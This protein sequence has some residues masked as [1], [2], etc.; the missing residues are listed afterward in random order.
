M[1]KKVLGRGL[2][3]LIPDAAATEPAPNEIDIDRITANPDQ[4]RLRFDEQRLNE[5]AESIRQNGILQPLLVRRSG[6]NYQLVAGER[7][8]MAAQRAGLLK[9]PAYIRDIPD[10]RLLEAALI[11]NIQREQLNPI[12]EAQAY[13]NLMETLACTQE[14]LAT[15][16]GKD[17]STIANSLRLL[18]LPSAVK[19][20]VAEGELSPGHARALLSA[21][22]SPAEITQ[23]ARLMI[24]KGWSV[25]EAERWAKKTPGK[26]SD[27]QLPVPDPNVSAAE[28]RL[29]VLLGTRVEIVSADQDKGYIRIHFF[30][31]DDLTRIFGIIAENRKH[32]EGGVR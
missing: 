25:R 12:E 24:Q 30:T 17:R 14:E 27:R 3:V 8:W 9:V 32:H 11:E 19:L 26:L 16:L 29:R 10:E 6:Q 22:V 31:Q 15:R 7:R 2:G 13:F 23:T 5:L 20:L 4:P 28:D 21:N 1:K 18:K